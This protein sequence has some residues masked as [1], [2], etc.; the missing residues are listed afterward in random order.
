MYTNQNLR[1]VLTT[2]NYRYFDRGLFNLN[3]IG[4]RSVASISDHFDD[5]LYVSYRDEYGKE[6]IK[7]YCITTDPGKKYLRNPLTGTEGAL[8][9]V[10]GQYLHAYKLGIHG[11]SRPE[12]KQYK[13]LE[14]I[15]DIAYVRDCNKDDII[16]VSLYK[17]KDKDKHIFWG[18]QKSNIHRG[19][20]GWLKRLKGEHLVDAFSAGCQV[21]QW[22]DEFNEFIKL[23]E[24]ASLYQGKIFSYTLLEEVDFVKI[25]V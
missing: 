1:S 12:A 14:Q 13:A 10:P 5:T 18:N 23:C 19:N 9:M 17:G 25:V 24:T 4:V 3:I 21:F 22:A 15:T 16:D 8:V 7:S 11:R 6:Q 2:K 20:S